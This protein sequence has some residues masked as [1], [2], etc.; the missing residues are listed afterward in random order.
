LGALPTP[1]SAVDGAPA[2]NIKE[3]GDEGDRAA[4]LPELSRAVSSVNDILEQVVCN[5]P[6]HRLHTSRPSNDLPWRKDSDDFPSAWSE[7]GAAQNEVSVPR[8]SRRQLETLVPLL[9]RLGR[10][11]TDAAPHVASFAATLPENDGQSSGSLLDPD[12]DNVVIV[13]ETNEEPAPIEERSPIGST[14]GGGLFSLLSRDSRARN[15]ASATQNSGS[16]FYTDNA[17]ALELRE[18]AES[19][20]ADFVDFVNGMVNTTRGDSRSGV[21]RGGLDDSVSGLLG[22][23][24]ALSSLASDGSSDNDDNE[25]GGL[26]G[27]GRLLRDR[28]N[29]GGG[30]DIHIHAIVTGPGIVPGT[31]P[32]TIMGEPP[33]ETNTGGLPRGLFSGGGRRGSGESARA[34]SVIHNTDEEDDMGIFAD[35][36]SENPAPLDPHGNPIRDTNTAPTHD[37]GAEGDGAELNSHAAYSRTRSGLETRPTSRLGSFASQRNGRNGHSPRRGSTVGRSLRN[38]L[39]PRRRSHRPSGHDSDSELS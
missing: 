11:L 19:N 38:L 7:N 13:G 23:Y 20:G 3:E 35:L 16:S 12:A 34:T 29:N 25:G 2:T 5:V 24:L 33:M 37:E 6:E 10:A 17:D 36:Y 26:Q 32:M 8:Y 4:L 31:I 28:G 15:N 22:A 27:L 14:G 18:E 30:I 1:Q 21:R 39:S 9:D